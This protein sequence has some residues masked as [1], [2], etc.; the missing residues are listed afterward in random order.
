MDKR[1]KAWLLDISN[2]I[3]EIEMDLPSEKNFFLYQ[4]N[5]TAKRAIERNLEIIGEAM[6][7][8]S[9]K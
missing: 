4:Q 2:A 9:N 3:Q 5:R 8:N 7:G 6:N 1:I